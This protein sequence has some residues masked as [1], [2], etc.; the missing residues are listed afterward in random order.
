M[1]QTAAAPQSQTWGRRSPCPAWTARQLAGHLVDGHRQ[2]Q[3]LLDGQETVTP[4]TDPSRLSRLA[5]QDPAR[6][7][8]AAAAHVRST[9]TGLDPLRVVETPR[10]PLPVEQLLAMALIE[11]VVH[12]WDL[13]V[14]TGQPGTLDSELTAALLPGVQQL[15][16]EL[17]ASGM[18][19]QALPV[20]DGATQAE[21]LLAAL[22]RKG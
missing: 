8:Q 20:A 4:T 2:V 16:G 5:G 3:A 7:L 19:S 1:E 22:G 12:G 13:A 17:A 11:P 14:A 18:Y 15:G 9:L 21:Q 6:A 10:G